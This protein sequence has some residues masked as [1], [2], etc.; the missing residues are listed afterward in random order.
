MGHEMQWVMESVAVHNGP[1]RFVN[2]EE[3][4]YSRGD[5]GRSNLP[6]RGC[7]LD[8]HAV[9]SRLARIAGTRLKRAVVPKQPP[10]LYF[11]VSQPIKFF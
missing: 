4:A 6:L 2:G 8:D 7:Q 9:R 5:T 3:G 11:P 1:Q 10:F